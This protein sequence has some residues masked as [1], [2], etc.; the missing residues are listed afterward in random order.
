MHNNLK[1]DNCNNTSIWLKKNTLQLLKLNNILGLRTDILN[2]FH[3]LNIHMKRSEVL[4]QN[5]DIVIAQE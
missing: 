1:K 2:I 5:V 3:E 4:F